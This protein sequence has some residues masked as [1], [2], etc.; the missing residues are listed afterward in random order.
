ML[1]EPT[2][3]ETLEEIDRYESLSY[4][5]WAPLTC[6][7]RFCDAMIQIRREAED[8]IT[9]K[10]PKDNNVLKNAPHPI[11][12]IAFSEE[13]WNRWGA[14]LS[15]LIKRNSLFY[16]YSPYS[17][18]IA[19]YPVPWLLEKKFWPTVSRIDDGKCQR[20]IFAQY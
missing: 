18:Q 16:L 5:L 15:G 8:I 19:A 13:A 3:S 2:E 12:V 14:P 20:C 17:R 6:S 4:H 11:S 1:I 9:G 7:P 10:Q